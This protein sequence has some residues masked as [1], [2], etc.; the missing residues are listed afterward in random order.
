MGAC[1]SRCVWGAQQIR[2]GGISPHSPLETPSL[3]AVLGPVSPEQ[4][5]CRV[6]LGSRPNLCMN[7]LVDQHIHALVPP[8]RRL[9]SFSLP[10]TLRAV[11]SASGRSGRV[12]FLRLFPFLLPHSRQHCQSHPTLLLLVPSSLLRTLEYSGKVSID[13]EQTAKDA[14]VR[15]FFHNSLHYIVKCELYPPIQSA[16]VC[17]PPHNSATHCPRM[18]LRVTWY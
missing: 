1:I 3:P 15:D 9:S 2:Y 4:G 10:C 11:E 13:F 7:A 14:V 6:L 18:N 16:G 17:N 8:L 12:C 5:P